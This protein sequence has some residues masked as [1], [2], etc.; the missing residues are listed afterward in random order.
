MQKLILALCLVATSVAC[1]DNNTQ[2]HSVA[3]KSWQQLSEE[4]RQ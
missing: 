1:T 4:Q 2:Y 3:D